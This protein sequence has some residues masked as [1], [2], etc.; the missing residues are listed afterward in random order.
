M[1]LR[2]T[3]FIPETF[4]PYRHY[5]IIRDLTVNDLD[6]MET[7]INSY[8]QGTY[9]VIPI[10]ERQHLQTLFAV[11]RTDQEPSRI[12]PQE[13][14][15]QKP[16]RIVRALI[17][18]LVALAAHGCQEDEISGE[19]YRQMGEWYYFSAKDVLDHENNDAQFEYLFA[20]T[21]LVTSFC[22]FQGSHPSPQG[23][24]CMHE[25]VKG[26][27]LSRVSNSYRCP[28]AFSEWL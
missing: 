7:L 17:F 12:V 21:L 11:F 6:M 4:P 8:F 5:K 28:D 14:P 27:T 9:S 24:F 10:A 15:T 3:N 19:L 16:S 20:S 23:W 26:T 13:P 2:I 22:K 18:G 1:G 25:S